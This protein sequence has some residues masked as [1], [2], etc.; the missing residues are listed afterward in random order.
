MLGKKPSKWVIM[1]RKKEDLGELASD[2]RWNQ[3][4]YNSKY[5]L[6]SD[7]FSNIL[8][9]FNWGKTRNQIQE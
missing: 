3:I 9:I 5:P 1:A 6:W 8:T 2:K 7:D 4:T